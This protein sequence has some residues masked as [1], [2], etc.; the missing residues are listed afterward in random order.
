M[1]RYDKRQFKDLDRSRFIEA[2]AAEGI[3]CSGGYS[4]LNW[5]PFLLRTLNSTGF[6]QIYSAQ[7]VQDWTLRN[8]CPENDLLCSEAVWLGQTQLL[9]PQ[10]DMDDITNAIRKI[11]SAAESLA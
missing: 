1:F 6:R 2:M 4:P 3:P 11:Q 9:G 5:E 10:Q 8:Q 7:F